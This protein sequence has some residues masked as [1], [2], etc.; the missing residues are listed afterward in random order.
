MIVILGGPVAILLTKIRTEHIVLTIIRRLLHGLVITLAL[1]IS[2]TVIWKANQNL[3]LDAMAIF[4]ISMAY[5]ALRREYFSDVRIIAPI[6]AKFGVKLWKKQK[7]SG[8]EQGSSHF[9]PLMKWRRGGHSG[10]NDG[11]GPEGQH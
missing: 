11:H 3:A 2:S 5:I 7:R 6:L 4:G 10:G 9:G 1:F 8:S